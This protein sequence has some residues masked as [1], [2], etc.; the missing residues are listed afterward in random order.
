MYGG[1]DGQLIK[2]AVDHG[3]KGIVV[4]GLLRAGET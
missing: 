4:Q 2:A 3:A 1:A